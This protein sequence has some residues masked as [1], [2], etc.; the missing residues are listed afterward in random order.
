MLKIFK[1]LFVFLAG[2]F[3]WLDSSAANNSPGLKNYCLTLQHENTLLSGQ[4]YCAYKFL[5]NSCYGNELKDVKIVLHATTEIE[6]SIVSETINI[7]TI[8][9][10]RAE[11]YKEELV[12]FPCDI[13]SISIKSAEATVNEKKIDL[14]S[15]DILSIYDGFEPIKIYLDGR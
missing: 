10:S 5:F 3:L 12:E 4:G 14:I 15:T 7:S 8:G 6:K 9:S 2:S 1:L 11:Q 13:S